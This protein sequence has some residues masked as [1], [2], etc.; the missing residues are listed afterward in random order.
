MRSLRVIIV[1][2]G[3]E[4]ALRAGSSAHPRLMKSV[5]AHRKCVNY[6][7]LL[8]P[9]CLAAV[10]HSWRAGLSRTDIVPRDPMHGRGPTSSCRPA[11]GVGAVFVRPTPTDDEECPADLIPGV[12]ALSP[13]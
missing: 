12:L 9:S 5:D 6:P 7:A 10:G 13:S 8:A 1:D 3:A 11:V 4:P 2:E